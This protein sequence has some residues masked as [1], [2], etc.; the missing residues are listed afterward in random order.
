MSSAKF[1]LRDSAYICS[2]SGW[3]LGLRTPRGILVAEWSQARHSKGRPTPFLETSYALSSL[4]VNILASQ[5]LWLIP[6]STLTPT[7]KDVLE[8]YCLTGMLWLREVK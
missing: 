1:S 4:H 5:V 7:I 8:S 3:L 2:I 6:S